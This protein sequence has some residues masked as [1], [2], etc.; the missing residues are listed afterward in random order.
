MTI[1]SIADLTL[2]L[3][4]IAASG[5]TSISDSS[6]ALAREFALSAKELSEMLPSG[7]QARFANRVRWAKVE[8]GM[9]GLIENTRPKHFRATAHGTTVLENAPKRLDY[10]FLMQF[11]QY[12]QKIEK[13]RKKE[14]G[15]ELNESALD[16]NLGKSD[17]SPDEPIE[18]L[19]RKLGSALAQDLLD[20]IMTEPP[21][22]FENLIVK[23]MLAM[24]YGGSEEEAGRAIGGPGDGGVDGVIDEDVLGLDVIYLQAKRYKPGNSIGRSDVQ[25]FVGSLVGH[26]ANKGVFVTTASFTQ[27]ALDYAK[28][29]PQRVILI[30]GE[31]LTHLMIRHGI[32]VRTVKSYDVKKVD[33]DFF[34][35]ELA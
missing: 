18:D 8:L 20:R 29:V 30:D 9:A 6:E 35:S 17:I 3:L 12:R 23:L 1:P 10:K 13:S 7:L 25:S 15:S 21:Q 34:S 14:S 2:P 33:E 22:F 24:G 27:N 16:S 5:E 28:L 19:F 11:D 26:G 31:Q 32:G 4:R